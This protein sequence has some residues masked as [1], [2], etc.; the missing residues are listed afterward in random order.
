MKIA[1]VGK[2][3]KLHDE[4]YIA[5]SFEMLG[6]D[7]IRIEHC[8][9]QD[10]IRRK[11]LL[12]Q[13]DMLLFTKWEYGPII[14]D[15]IQKGRKWGIKTVCWLFDLYIGYE[16]EYRI[17]TASY[18]KADYVFTTDGGHAKGWES[19]NINH[20]CVRQGIYE[21]ECVL[22]PRKESEGKIVFIGSENPFYPE[23]TKIMLSLKGDYPGFLWIGR[24]NTDAV[25]GMDLNR[26]FAEASIVVGDSVCSPHYWSNRVVETLGRG[27]FLIHRDVPGIKEEYPDLVTYDGT[28]ED[29]KKKIDYFLSHKEEREE[30]IKKNFHLVKSRYTM[31]KKCN[32]LLSCLKP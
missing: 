15:A 14:R 10:L 32:E 17:K 30:I 27:G 13:P 20:R 23:R 12:Q 24:I 19:C 16:R 5:R 2:F 8:L 1:F 25:R 4:E 31:E 3:S 26:I 18:F 9:S 6:H 28:Y 22:L 11:I 29:L 7:V 21:K